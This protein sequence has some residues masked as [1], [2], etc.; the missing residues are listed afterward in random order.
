M[1]FRDL[2]DQLMDYEGTDIY[3]DLLAPFVPF[4]RDLVAS[5]SHFSRL[6]S[7]M[8][9]DVQEE[10][11]WT[12][13]AIGAC[14]DLLLDPL[15]VSKAQYLQFFQ[16]LGFTALSPNE[17]FNPV[18]HEIETLVHYG[19]SEEGITAFPWRPGLVLGE[20]IFSRCGVLVRCDPS[21]GLIKGIADVSTLYFTSR[22]FRR[23]RTDLSVGW[24]HNSRWRTAY[25]RDYVSHNKMFLNV[26]GTIDL[27]RDS[28]ETRAS[29][30][31]LSL[32]EARELLLNRC[33][34]RSQPKDEGDY[35]PYKWRMALNSSVKVWPLSDEAS[36]PFEGAMEELRESKN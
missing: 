25:R 28:E 36:L 18:L 31:S 12:L 35:F 29:L 6:K 33:F 27:Y 23:E 10:D 4:G 22:R 24:G 20:L 9:G 30:D 16:E 5:I 2:Y 3:H 32:D 13:H 34:V 15:S 8:P 17:S 11:L 14:N 19:K 1:D 26:D 21:W 7:S